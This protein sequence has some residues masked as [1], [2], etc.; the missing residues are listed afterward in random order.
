[1]ISGSTGKLTGRCLA[2]GLSPFTM[3]ITG[4]LLIISFNSSLLAYGG[5]LAMGAMT[6]LSSA[7][8]FNVLPLQ[9]ITQG[10][11]PILSY[12]LGAGN[13]DRIRKVF[14][15]EL[16]ACLTY[17]AFVWILCQVAPGFVSSIFTTDSA[18]AR[19]T[20]WALRIYMFGILIFGMQVGCQQTF[21]ALG[22]AA[23]SLFLAV[24]RKIILLIPLIYIRPVFFGDKV[25]AVFLAE[26]ISDII[27]SLTTGA[28][29][30][31]YF[32]KKL[33][34]FERK[35]QVAIIEE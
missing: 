5:D 10:A 23:T 6:I 22:N 20:D 14:K 21:V 26:P 18:L 19:Y 35:E 11:Q 24:F 31:R 8:Q 2:L 33:P 16:T 32:K 27:A 28:I 29:C 34:T 13:I 30:Y 7:M 25:F 4:S 15:L 3:Q 1:M 17:S 9:G 12:N